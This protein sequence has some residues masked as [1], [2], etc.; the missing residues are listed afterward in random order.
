MPG[1]LLR[2]PPR[3]RPMNRVSDWPRRAVCALA[4]LAG[5]AGVALLVASW[6]PYEAVKV[7]LDLLAL[8][9]SAGFFDAGLHARLTGGLRAAGAAA[10]LV[11]I[12]LAAARNAVAGWIGSLSTSWRQTVGEARLRIIRW[13]HTED[14]WH[15]AALAVI[16]LVGAILRAAF[17]TQPMRYDESY[18]YMRYASQPLLVAVTNYSAPNNHIFHTVLVHFAVL[19]LGNAPWVIRLPALLAGIAM[20]PAVYGMTRVFQEKN[21]ALLAA[22]LV[23]ASSALVEFSANARGYTLMGLFTLLLF[24]LAPR[25]ARAPSLG[26]WSLF[27][28]LASL[29]FYTVPVMLYPAGSIALWYVLFAWLS[30]E[31]PDRRRAVGQLVVA[32]VVIGALTLLLYTPVF[33]AFGLGGVVGNQFV[34]PQPWPQFTTDALRTLDLIR[35]QWVRDIPSGVQWLLLLGLAIGLATRRMTRWQVLAM[36]LWCAPVV[37]LQRNLAYRRVWLFALPIALSAAAGGIEALVRAF[38]LFRRGHAQVVAFALVSLLT[39]GGLGGTVWLRQ[40]VYYSDETETL[41]DAP[42]IV[43]YLEQQLLP[44]DRVLTVAPADTILEYYFARGR[45]PLS[46]LVAE[47][48]SAGSVWVV[49]NDTA[50]GAGQSLAEILE[51]AGVEDSAEDFA[52]V[53]TYDTARVYRLSR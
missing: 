51:S 32:L 52:L 37:M 26:L 24:A 49:V 47:P 29:G 3:Q 14:R 35:G 31:I 34:T 38:R 46:H 22:G 28:L 10:L 9:R 25:L 18:T 8:D 30:K 17:V 15:L 16:I 13:I 39:V 40:S 23:A 19:L 50:R 48:Q 27:V 41:R 2:L 6:T 43:A 53:R 20:I 1:A 7:R 36:L 42:K 21:A 45:V 11:A 5:G 33:V 12:S 44:G 4:L